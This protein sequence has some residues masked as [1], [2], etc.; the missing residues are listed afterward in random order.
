MSIERL[1]VTE[2]ELKNMLHSIVRDMHKEHYKPEVIVGPNRGGLQI[3]V[4]LSHYF[5]VPFVP[6]QWQTRDGDKTD[7][8]NLLAFVNDYREKNI[9]LID[10]INDTGKTLNSITETIYQDFVFDLKVAVLFNKTTSAFETVDYS[11]V[12]LTPDYN[13]WIVFPYEEWWK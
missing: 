5:D 1:V 2:A 11:A 7:H 8:A 10:D 4:M 6:L 9:L 12:E 13:P 3:G